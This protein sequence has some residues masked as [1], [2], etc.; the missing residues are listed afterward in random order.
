M[1]VLEAIQKSADFLAKKGVESPRL[2]TE[3][4]LAHLL[5]LLRMKL[6]L[7]FERTLTLPEVDALRE[8]VRRRGQCEPLQHITG[9]T[10]FCGLEIA[11]NR[12]ALVPRQETEL[13]A[14][15]GWEFLNQISEGRV[16]RA[17]KLKNEDGNSYN[18]SLRALDFGTG[19][20]CIAIALAVKCPTAKIVATDISADALSLAKE[21]ATRN[22]VAERIEFLQ[23]DGF[24]AL[25]SEGRVTRVPESNAAAEIGDSQSSSLRKMGFDLI[26]SNPPYIPA[27]EISTLQPE[28]RDFDPRCALDGGADGLDFYRLIA[29]QAVAFLRPGGKVML[30]FGDGQVGAIRQIFEN[31][32]WI[33]EAVKED[34]SHRARILIVRK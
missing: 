28:V 4:L 25:V 1:T 34:Y 26:I 3:L 18:S 22:G 30:E 14:E 21:N 5:K 23:G 27:A 20:G 6:Y 17:P 2:Q 7:N 32:K 10:S 19:T 33:V 11:V 24:A 29:S 13:L 12:H 15:C 9:S 16:T 8:L 31:E